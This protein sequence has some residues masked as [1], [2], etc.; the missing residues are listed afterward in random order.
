[1]SGTLV[2]QP[3]VM[4]QVQYAEGMRWHAGKLWLSDLFG[5][6][7]FTVDGDRLE[8]QATLG[9]DEPSGLGFL[10]D[11]TPL[12]VAMKTGQLRTIGPGGVTALHADMSIASTSECNDMLVDE[13][14]RAYVSN[15]GY[16]VRG[17][18]EPAPGQLIL[19]RPGEEP[20]VAARDLIFPNGIVLTPDGSTL[21]VSQLFGEE[22]TAFDVAADGSLAGRRVFAKL[23]GVAPDG[24]AIDAEGAVWVSA[25]TGCEYLRVLDGG[26]ITD[27]IA[28]P[29]EW[30]PS[31][32]LGGDDGRT[33]F[34]GSAVTTLD[35]WMAGRSTSNIRTVRVDVPA[36]RF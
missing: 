24:L 1:M 36:A 31:C 3:L 7:V 13:H 11:G 16:D 32:A 22:L 15:F 34:L 4:G 2:P 12:L 10:P 5:R 6:T 28:I 17:G 35:D 33:L 26:E 18:G 19:V 20:L 29:G 8:A 30:T 9:D 21:V 25:S 27:R 14:G 23:P